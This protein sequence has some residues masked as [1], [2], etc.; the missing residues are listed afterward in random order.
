MNNKLKHQIREPKL[1]SFEELSVF[2]G[3]RKRKVSKFEMTVVACICSMIFGRNAVTLHFSAEHKKSIGEAAYGGVVFNLVPPSLRDLVRML[4]APNYEIGDQFTKSRWFVPDAELV[5]FLKLLLSIRKRSAIFAC[6]DYLSGTRTPIYWIKQRFNLKMSNKVER[7]YD[8]KVGFFKKMI[9]EDLI[10]TCAV[11]DTDY[12]T[13]ESAQSRKVELIGSRLK[14]EAGS[15]VLDV[16]CGWG[17][18]AQKYSNDYSAYVDGITI[19]STQFNHFYRL[20]NASAVNEP[21]VR[22]F[23]KSL[24]AYSGSADRKYDRIYSVGVF[25][26]FGEYNQRTF[27]DHVSSL[28]EDDGLC[29][30]HCVTAKKSRKPNAWIE[31]NIFPG[32]FV[33][34]KE[35]VERYIRESGMEHVI[36]HELGPEQ[37][38]RT[39]RCWHDRFRANFADKIGSDASLREYRTIQFYLASCEASFDDDTLGL[40]VCHYICKK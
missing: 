40:Q 31:R 7:H 36:T 6:L 22:V 16:G 34:T 9:G 39:L 25:E 20:L 1:D 12:D 8:E 21:R 17:S 18:M 15:K 26:H 32:H 38:A 27:F 28:L 35:D 33:P 13:L 2:F 24:Q 29:L 10:Y 19:S 37:Y 11:F 23:K 30:T 3:R 5:E 4:L 14:I